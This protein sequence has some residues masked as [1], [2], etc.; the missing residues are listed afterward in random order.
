[1]RKIVACYFA[2]SLISMS[3]KQQLVNMVIENTTAYDCPFNIVAINMEREPI[4]IKANDKIIKAIPFGYTAEVRNSP[5]HYIEKKAEYYIVIKLKP[6]QNITIENKT[7]FDIKVSSIPFDGKN[8]INAIFPDTQVKKNETG[9]TVTIY[10]LQSE[11]DSL[12]VYTNISHTEANFIPN[13]KKIIIVN[14]KN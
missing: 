3:C 13:E 10:C 12:K 5:K 11:F 4:V 14:S 6:T 9:K 8:R 1:M 7:N 2:L